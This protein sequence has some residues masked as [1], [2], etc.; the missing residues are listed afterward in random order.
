MS[1]DPH[2]EPLVRPAIS[3]DD[4]VRV[5]RERYGIAG[6]VSELGSN[7]DRNFLLTPAKRDHNVQRYLLKFDNAAYLTQ[8]IQTQND[9]LLRLSAAGLTVPAPVKSPAGNTIEHALVGG[10]DVRVRLLTFVEGESMVKDGVLAPCVIAQLGALAGRVV[11]VLATF[12]ST[13]LDRS[14]QWDLRNAVPVVEGYIDSVAADR[15]GQ[16]LAATKIAYDQV[17]AVA[18]RLPIQPIHGD[19][20]DDNVV[21]SR[22][23]FGRVRP[24]A[25]IDWGDMG[26]GYRVAEIAVAVSSVLHHQG[27]GRAFDALPAIAAFDAAAG[28]PLSDAEI[29]ALWP[30]VVLRGAVL[31]VSG[32]QQV[33]LEPGNTYAKER[34]EAEWRLFEIAAELDT[35]VAAAGIRAALGREASPPPSVGTLLDR[36]S[37]AVRLDTASPLLAAGVWLRGEEAE[38]ALAEKVYTARFAYGEHRLTRTIGPGKERPVNAALFTELTLAEPVALTAPFAAEV[39]ATAD[40][41]TLASPTHGT[42]RLFGDVDSAPSG[43]VAE[44]APLG[45]A[46]G[47]LK[48]QW[49]R[50]HAPPPPLFTDADSLPAWK[51]LTY[52]PA[53]L[54]AAPPADWLPDVAA[55]RTRREAAVAGAAERY[56]EIPPDIE[57]GWRELLIDTTGR[58]YLDMVNNVAGIGHGHPAM[59]AAV[60]QQLLT[61]NTNSRFLYAS[62]ADYVER[63]RALAPDPSLSVVML[64]NSGS[65]AV[66][67]ALKLARAHTGRQDVLALREAYHG[68][69]GFTDAVSTS[70]YDNPYAAASRPAWV[71]VADA[72]NTYRGAH[73]DTDSRDPGAKYVA[74][75]VR[76]LDDLDA[77]G[78]PVG[79]FLAE[80]VFG[81]GGGVLLPDGYLE[82]VYAAVRARGGVCISDEVQVGLGRLGHYTWGVEQQRVVPD[83]IAV[84]K[85]LGNGYPLG[86]VYTTQAIADSLVREGMF[87]SSA[88][89][90]TASAVAG[91]AVLD[92]MRDEALQA[93]AAAVGDL[94]SAGFADL[95]KRHKLIGKVHGMG[96]YQGVE[97]VRDRATKQPAPEETDWIC[98]RL[99]DYGVIMQATSERRNV[100]KIKPPLTL[101]PAHARV[102]LD[103][104]DAVLGELEARA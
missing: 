46:T 65:E 51:R 25:V 14:L 74:D 81:N 59:A 49:A 93:N 41:F 88:G 22:D 45:R 38:A 7:Q 36:A 104:L 4:A 78:R 61:L 100:L 94:L 42:L 35:R 55:E 86:A 28:T 17:S 43:A 64:V 16:V 80:P 85:A 19:I 40:G 92:V 63:L 32:A 101:T 62:L 97:L 6:S 76:L 95:A 37:T 15:R 99:L 70:A 96:L 77:Q 52:D 13:G 68:W 2:A 31:V 54:V 11:S 20:T 57:R 56:Y 23:A 91:L 102:F 30:L 66:D 8:E 33:A 53:A 18:S 87:F 3:A 79:A 12:P 84:A 73:R 50:A 10:K 44:G 39:A 75:A 89:G 69:T 47:R 90:G 82:G 26:T 103:A 29:D 9:A 24:T 27:A 83:I 48:V 67:L 34:M 98:E 72:P 21:G 1:F 71:H 60:N 58:C 5:A